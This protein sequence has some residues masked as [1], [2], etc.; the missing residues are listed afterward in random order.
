MST[1]YL[2]FSEQGYKLTD[3]YY[4]ATV[5]NVSGRREQVLFTTMTEAP[6]DVKYRD[7]T[8][9]WSGSREDIKNI[10]PNRPLERTFLKH[11][12]MVRL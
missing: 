12:R 11:T 6:D 9:V 10:R 2:I 3:R 7:K 5:P 1:T 4:M 8:I